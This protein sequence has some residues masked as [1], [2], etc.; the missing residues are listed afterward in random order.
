MLEPF[1]TPPNLDTE[2]KLSTK[3]ARIVLAYTF[4]LMF[5]HYVMK[6]ECAD[7]NEGK[8]STT[9]NDGTDEF[10]KTECEGNICEDPK[11][12]LETANVG[13]TT[14][15]PPSKWRNVT[16][17]LQLGMASNISSGKT[18]AQPMDTEPISKTNQRSLSKLI[19]E[20][21]TKKDGSKE[22]DVK[23]EA[24]ENAQY[25]PINKRHSLGKFFKYGKSSQS[26]ES[27]IDYKNIELQQT[28]R[29][30]LSRVFRNTFNIE[31]KTKS[32]VFSSVERAENVKFD[33]PRPDTSEQP[34]GLENEPEFPTS[35]LLPG[36]APT[37]EEIKVYSDTIIGDL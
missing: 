34:Y 11:I 25:L 35:S 23:D 22:K 21:F 6:M 8:E 31:K 2:M 29:A 16:K 30:S 33:I 28:K 12:D 37:N 10:T 9:N 13:D 24:F 18:N 20:K 27:S 7:I 3:R 26:K 14:Y 15:R 4:S 5:Q 36:S 17:F 32:S 1:K 19:R